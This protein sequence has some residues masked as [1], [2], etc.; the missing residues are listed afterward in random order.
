MTT[1]K[2]AR[3]RREIQKHIDKAEA[4]L[5]PFASN[6]VVYSYLIGRRVKVGDPAIIGELRGD[7]EGPVCES[8]GALLACETCREEPHATPDNGKPRRLLSDGDIWSIEG[9]ITH[10]PL[11]VQS[12][13]MRHIKELAK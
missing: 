7:D 8:C 3:R 2:T 5:G 12:I 10:L 4:A 9:A 13:L 6:A 11:D 1:T